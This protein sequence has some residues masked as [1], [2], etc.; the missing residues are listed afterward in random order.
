MAYIKFKELTHYF[1]FY[2]E[3]DIDK[4]PEYICQYVSKDETIEAVYSNRLDRCLFSDK[5]IILFDKFGLFENKMMPKKIHFFPYKNIS[6]TAILFN[7]RKV[8][9]FITMNSGYQF[10]INFVHMT[11]KD[12]TK[13]RETY[14]KLV[15]KI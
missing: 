11:P 8:V 2:K 12:K 6:S 15:E 7:Y 9:I 10:K 13:I 14:Y 5:K 3:L 1:N 4:L